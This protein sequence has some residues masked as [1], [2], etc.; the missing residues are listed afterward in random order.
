MIPSR[1]SPEIILL[2]NIFLGRKKGA[3]DQIGAPFV[4]VIT[5]NKILITF[6]CVKSYINIS[7]L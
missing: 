3:A 4:I 1:P 5:I 7:H 6:A 2:L